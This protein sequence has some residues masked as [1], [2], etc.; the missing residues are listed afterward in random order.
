MVAE[1]ADNCSYNARI[2]SDALRPDPYPLHEQVVHKQR[3]LRSFL[4]AG[5]VEGA[6]FMCLVSDLYVSKQWPGSKS[7]Y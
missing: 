5:E 4:G 2:A 1:H 7:S 3:T 6:A